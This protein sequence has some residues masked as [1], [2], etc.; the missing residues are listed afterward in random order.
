MG[1]PITKQRLSHWV[2]GGALVYTGQGL[3]APVGPQADFTLVRFYRLDVS[4]SCVAHAG[5]G[6]GA[7]LEQSTTV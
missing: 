3:Q 6:S 4:A 2:L 7:L 1:K 5:L